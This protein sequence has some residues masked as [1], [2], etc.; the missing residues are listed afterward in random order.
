MDDEQNRAYR[1]KQKFEVVL[2]TLGTKVLLQQHRM[3]DE[4]TERFFHS[5]Q[6][7]GEKS[8]SELISFLYETMDPNGAQRGQ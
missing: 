7:F 6:D 2:R 4:R 3:L 8:A 5:N 1:Y